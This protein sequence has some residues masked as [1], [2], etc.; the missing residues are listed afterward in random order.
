MWKGNVAPLRGRKLTMVI[1]HLRC[2]MGWSCKDSA[3]VTEKLVLF[4]FFLAFLPALSLLELQI[5]ATWMCQP[6]F[7]DGLMVIWSMG[8]L[9]YTYKGDILGWNNPMMLTF[10]PSTSWDIQALQALWGGKNQQL[11]FATRIDVWKKF[12]RYSPKTTNPRPHKPLTPR[13]HDHTITICEPM[14]GFEVSQRYH[15]KEHMFWLTPKKQN[16]Y[17]WIHFDFV[18]LHLWLVLC[19]RGCKVKLSLQWIIGSLKKLLDTWIAKAKSYATI[20]NWGDL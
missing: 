15:V 3:W 11:R 8:Y 5:C 10:D 14:K 1:N 19:L 2:F 17:C 6:G 7:V 16:N 13:N 4:A 12:Q 20:S 9:T 18:F